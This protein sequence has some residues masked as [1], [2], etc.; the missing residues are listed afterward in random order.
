MGAYGETESGSKTEP[1]IV[2]MVGLPGSG[3]S[4]WL[5]RQGIHPLSSDALRLLLFDDENNQSNHR[6]VFATLRSLLRR[7][8]ELRRPVT[9]VDA[10]HLSIR[11]R[12]PYLMM[13][14]LYGASVEVLWFDEDYGLSLARNR[15][16]Q[17]VVPTEIMEHMRDRM[18]P[19][20]LAEGY[21]RIT[22]IRNGQIWRVLPKTLGQDP[23]GEG[24]Q[25]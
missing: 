3:K 10:T 14:E 5:A 6:A 19:P 13:G 8:L 20:T 15:A 2:L 7:R 16:R 12:R 9:Y 22:I 18:Q 25:Q 4:T 21:S 11:E 23:Q 1:R 24:Q 17:R